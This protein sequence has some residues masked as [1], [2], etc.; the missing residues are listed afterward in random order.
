MATRTKKTAITP[1]DFSKVLQ[2]LEIL[3]I[4]VDEFSGKRTEN[5]RRNT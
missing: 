5:R 3:R 4:D 1:E 2:G